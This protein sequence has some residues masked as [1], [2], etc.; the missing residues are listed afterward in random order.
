[1]TFGDLDRATW[2]VDQG[3]LANPGCELLYRDRLRIADARGDHTALDEIMRD[4][5]THTGAEDSWVT[6]ETLQLFER[7]KRSTTI[8]AAPSNDA[9]ERRH[10]S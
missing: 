1:M 6:P 5:R 10:A 3:L 9:D 8:T 2:A 7:L 4:L